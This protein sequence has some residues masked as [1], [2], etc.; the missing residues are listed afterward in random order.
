[1]SV[2]SL[3][4]VHSFGGKLDE[5]PHPELDFARFAQFVEKKNLA[6]GEVWDPVDKRNKHWIDKRKLQ[7]TYGPK[8]CTIS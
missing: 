7:S 3:S 4:F 8:G 1:M 5:Y 6:A 2:L